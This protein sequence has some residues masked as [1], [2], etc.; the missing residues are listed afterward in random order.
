MTVLSFF[1]HCKFIIPLPLVY[2][3]SMKSEMILIIFLYLFDVFPLTLFKILSLSLLQQF[4]FDQILFFSPFLVSFL[5]LQIYNF[6]QILK[7][8]GHYFC[9]YIF[10]SPHKHFF[11]DSNDM[12]IR[13]LDIFFE[14]LLGFVFFFF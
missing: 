6:H 10:R 14:V 1:Q 4:H 7:F 13:P 2:I 3:I 12:C 9:K 5:D 8:S 11:L